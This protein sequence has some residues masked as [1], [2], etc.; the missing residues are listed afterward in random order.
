MSLLSSGRARF[1]SGRG[2]SSESAM[3][4]LCFQ[5]AEHAL[6]PPLSSILTLLH[7]TSLLPSGR[8]RFVPN[9]ELRDRIPPWLSLL[10]SG[11]ARFVSGSAKSANA[12]ES[13]SLLPSGRA[14]FVS[15]RHRRPALSAERLC[16]Q[17]AE[18]ALFRDIAKEDAE[19]ELVVSASKRQS[20]LCFGHQPN[21]LF[22]QAASRTLRALSFF[23]SAGSPKT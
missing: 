20:T 6:F 3:A 7:V 2:W 11:R 17:G 4:G 14:R 5:A 9:R 21:S 10:S 18:H 13:T 19:F 16:F 22:L 23:S 12:A 8:A 1:V 15:Y